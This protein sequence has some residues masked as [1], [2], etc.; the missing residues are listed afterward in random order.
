MDGSRPTWTVIWRGVCGIGI[1]H[2]AAGARGCRATD[3]P[4]GVAAHSRSGRRQLKESLGPIQHPQLPGLILLLGLLTSE[5]HL[6][7]HHA[8]SLGDERTFR[9]GAV[10][11]PAVA[12]M[13]LES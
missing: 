4:R 6:G 7:S 1:L 3:R 13:T 11:P 2:P 8:L 12:F 5:R 10:P 9:T